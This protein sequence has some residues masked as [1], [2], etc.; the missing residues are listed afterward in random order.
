[1][2]QAAKSK[3]GGV[4]PRLI[5]ASASPRRVALLRQLGLRFLIKPAQVAELTSSH[6]TPR[7]L[8]RFNAWRKA[9]AVA[10]AYPDALVLGADTVVCLGRKLFGKPS[11]LAQARRM[12]AQLQGRTH[13]VITGVCLVHL[14][15]RRHK[16]F[17]VSTR[18]TFRRLGPMQIRAY[19]Q[20]VN[21]LDKAGAYAIQENGH[22]IIARIAGSFSN[23]VGLPLERLRQELAAWGI[24]LP[25]KPRRSKA[26]L[27]LPS[28]TTDR[29]AAPT[30]EAGRRQKT[31][32]KRF[33]RTSS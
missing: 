5:L 33:S 19:L 28:S 29:L 18:V 1:M 4:R 23:V 12:L 16:T 24:A 2:A 25:P 17:A 20:R 21:P 13:E 15:E 9:W 7:E 10:Q 3:A 26:T 8:A 27:T 31:L 30:R 22:E 14:R 32:A 6:L 11:S